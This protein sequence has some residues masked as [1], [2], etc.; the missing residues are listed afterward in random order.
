MH[1]RNIYSERQHNDNI[2]MKHFFVYED[3]KK[4]FMYMYVI[5]IIPPSIYSI[6]LNTA[7][8]SKFLMSNIAIY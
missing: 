5:G 2:D 3:I 8:V 4:F 1:P 7:I 6:E